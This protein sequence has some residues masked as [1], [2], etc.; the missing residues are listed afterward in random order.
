MIWARLSVAIV[1]VTLAA[2]IMQAPAQLPQ[3]TVVGPVTTNH[4]MGSFST[5]QLQ[6]TGVGCAAGAISGVTTL[7]VTTLNSTTINNSGV[8][9]SGSLV[10]TG[11][12]PQL[13]LGAN[14]GNAGGLQLNGSTSGNNQFTTS[15]T[16]ALTIFGGSAANSGLQLLG[17]SNGTPAGDSISLR[18]NG[19]VTVTNNGT[20]GTAPFQ[21]GSNTGGNGQIVLQNNAG[22]N[23]IQI[24]STSGGQ[25]ALSG[26]TSGSTLLQPQAVASGTVTIPAGTAGLL[27]NA[28]NVFNGN[29]GNPTGTTSTT[30]VMG[31][32]G[33]ACSITM[34]NSTRMLI[35]LTA[36]LTNST[37]N[38]GVLFQIRFGT[39]TAPT[40]GTAVTGTG[41]GSNSFMVNN[42]NTANLSVS[43]TS[44]GIATG[45]TIGTTYWVDFAMEAL[46]G[47]TA[48][49]NNTFCS[50]VEL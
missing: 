4:C 34:K 50:M 2:M 26:A 42:G 3:V 13:T 14:G 19:T 48:T 28:D 15:A 39:G 32:I 33:S 43:G 9:T 44:T 5:L 46:T 40:N 17:T 30:L 38:D 35:V 12:S 25:I 21:V 1:A 27:T 47:G 45:L 7:G 37:A 18:A 31:G 11:V 36:L 10:G 29:G 41:V 6:D 49:V 22:A 23:Q 24:T 8:A 16:G 20:G